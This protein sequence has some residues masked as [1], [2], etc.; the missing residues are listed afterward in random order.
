MPK[1]HPWTHTSALPA[2]QNL[3]EIQTYIG[4]LQQIIQAAPRVPAIVRGMREV[5][6]GVAW[7]TLNSHPGTSLSSGCPG[8]DACEASSLEFPPSSLPAL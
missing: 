6:I 1:T 5:S 4:I 3:L 8:S 7:G 2:P